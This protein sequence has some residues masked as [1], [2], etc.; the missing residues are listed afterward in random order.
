MPKI[1]SAEQKLIRDLKKDTEMIKLVKCKKCNLIY[2]IYKCWVSCKC[3]C[4]NWI[5]V[6]GKV[7]AR[8][9]ELVYE[10]KA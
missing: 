2:S 5:Y 9:G 10:R 3:D 4:G 7:N 8:G 6:K 1:L